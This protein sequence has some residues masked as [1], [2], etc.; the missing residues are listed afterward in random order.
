MHGAVQ[1]RYIRSS[2]SATTKH[3]EH[4]R[5]E[6]DSHADTCVAGAN[7]RILGDAD[8]HVSVQAFTT[9]YKPQTN[10]P[11]ASVAT[12]WI[13]PLDGS[14]YILIIHEALDFGKRMDSSLINPNQLRAHGLRVEDVP[15]QF[16]SASSHSIYVPK[17]KITI[18]LT[19]DGVI[20]GFDSQRPS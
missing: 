14:P 9:E 20:S 7:T 19:T 2:G 17:H 4:T 1:T 16:E 11:I 13:D 10:I 5:C 8:R 6:L 18:P 3:S 12:L 15:R